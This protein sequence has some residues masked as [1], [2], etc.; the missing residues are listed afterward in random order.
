MA[1][2]NRNDLNLNN[3]NS[4]NDEIDNVENNETSK[5]FSNEKEIDI[6]EI[7]LIEKLVS[8][9]I[10]VTS[11]NS[12][13]DDPLKSSELEYYVTASISKNEEIFLENSNTK[14]R[15]STISNGINRFVILPHEAAYIDLSVNI[16]YNKELYDIRFS[17]FERLKQN[18]YLIAEKDNKLLIE[19][20]S[21]TPKAIYDNELIATLTFIK[22]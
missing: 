20:I 19:N 12:F 7:P 22:L 4:D 21:D 18:F 9:E 16:E 14:T 5:D 3:S 11:I 15:K 17:L 13:Y 2:K 8:D 10:V 6:N 1:R